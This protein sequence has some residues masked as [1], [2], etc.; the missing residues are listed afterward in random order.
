MCIRDSVP[1]IATVVPGTS[2]ANDG[3]G[4]L[5]VGAGW[6]STAD[7]EEG[8]QEA[9]RKFEIRNSKFE[10]RYLKLGEGIGSK[11]AIRRGHA[12]HIRYSVQTNRRKS[13]EQ[14]L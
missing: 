1:S 9:R 8:E 14:S 6:Q 13:S 12:E 7:E 4:E 5:V 2:R 3:A 11:I 10:V